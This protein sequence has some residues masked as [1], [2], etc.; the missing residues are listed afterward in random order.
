MAR[1]TIPTGTSGGER[2]EGRG[3][4]FTRAGVIGIF[5]Y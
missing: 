3:E 4:I 1:A 5:G 2:E